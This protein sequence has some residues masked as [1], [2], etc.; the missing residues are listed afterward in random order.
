[1][2]IESIA[3]VTSSTRTKGSFSILVD[4][5]GTTSAGKTSDSFRE[6]IDNYLVRVLDPCRQL[7]DFYVRF[8]SNVVDHSRE[9]FF[10][11]ARSSPCNLNRSVTARHDCLDSIRAIRKGAARSC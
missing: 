10:E 8:N 3:G 9:R 5:K 11:I 4:E 7:M 2:L 6:R 1:M